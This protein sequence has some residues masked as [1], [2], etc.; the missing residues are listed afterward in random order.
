MAV[1]ILLV[2]LLTLQNT[3]RAV[4]ELM[5]SWRTKLIF[6]SGPQSTYLNEVEANKM[7]KKNKIKNAEIKH[8]SP[9]NF[10]GFST[11]MPIVLNSQKRVFLSCRIGLVKIRVSDKKLTK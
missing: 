11:E 8:E 7:I 5:E 1:G 4:L 10:I 9:T 6:H 2:I 3:P